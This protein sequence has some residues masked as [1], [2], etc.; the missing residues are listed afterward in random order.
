MTG[1]KR[2]HTRS[3]DLETSTLGVLLSAGTSEVKLTYHVPNM[4]LFAGVTGAAFGAYALLPALSARR[5]RKSAKA[6]V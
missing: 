2:I 1:L 3:E 4:G 5:K 6:G